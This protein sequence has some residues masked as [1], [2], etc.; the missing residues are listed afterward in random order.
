MLFGRTDND[1]PILTRFY[2]VDVSEIEE[3][4]WREIRKTYVS[5]P[6][7][8]GG[9]EPWLLADMA[10][11]HKNVVAV[12]DA[13]ADNKPTTR[14]VMLFWQKLFN[15]H[16]SNLIFAVK[17]NEVTD[18]QIDLSGDKSALIDVPL[19]RVFLRTGEANLWF[20]KQ[21]IASEVYQLF[22]E[23]RPVLRCISCSS[24]FTASRKGQV[25]C[26]YRCGRRESMR[27]VRTRE[28]ETM[29]KTLY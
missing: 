12:M 18:N 25:Y 14:G 24:P 17:A 4:L 10:D 7:E 21:D 29:T 13:L 6:I 3:F 27:K 9:P 2:Q 23:K 22:S 20:V 8:Q 19:P 16:F 15:D 28:K 11:L 5:I 26:S 1:L